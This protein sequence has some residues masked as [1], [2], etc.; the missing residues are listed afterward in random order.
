ML[1]YDDKMFSLEINVLSILQN[2]EIASHIQV[3][4]EKI[5]KLF[6]II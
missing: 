4:Y 2:I 6:I 5:L 1:N 3:L